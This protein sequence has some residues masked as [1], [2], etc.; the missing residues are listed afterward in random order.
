M[1]NSEG[2]LREAFFQ[3]YLTRSKYLTY[4]NQAENEGYP[5]IAKLFRA[6]AQGDQAHLLSIFSKDWE[7]Q[8]QC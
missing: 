2:Y 4:A 6:A 3:E 8:F 7:Q 1:I 5:E